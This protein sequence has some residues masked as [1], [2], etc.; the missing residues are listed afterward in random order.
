MHAHTCIQITYKKVLFSA[1]L[2]LIDAGGGRISWLGPLVLQAVM[3]IFYYLTAESNKLKFIKYSKLDLKFF[4]L[5][6]TAIF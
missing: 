5:F 6:H 4:V 3:F 2:I 1:V